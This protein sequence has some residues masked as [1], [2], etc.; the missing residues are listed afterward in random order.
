MSSY[1]EWMD[2][3]TDTRGADIRGIEA[4]VEDYRVGFATLDAER[5]LGIWDLDYDVVYSPVELMQPVRGARG[6]DRYFR[7]VTQVFGR[8]VGMDVG[9]LTIDVLGDVAYAFFTFRFAAE[10][11]DGTDFA[12]VGRNTLVAHRVGA[13]WKGIH[14]H[15]SLTPPTDP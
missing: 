6:L 9:D 15:E 4:L 7:D 8:V 11:P 10:R 3:E 2:D 1:G 5:L 13:A 12:V 14:W